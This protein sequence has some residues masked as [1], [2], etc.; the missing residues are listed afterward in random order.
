MRSMKHLILSITLAFS[1]PLIAQQEDF[2]SLFK[3]NTHLL[4]VDQGAFDESG[5]G[6]LNE[7]V[8]DAQFIMIGEAHGLAEVQEFSAMLFDIAHKEGFNIMA[9]ETDPFAADKIM[10]LAKQ[11]KAAATEFCRNFPMSIPFF[12]SEEAMIFARKLESISGKKLSIWGLD[13][14]FAVGPRLI[15]SQLVKIAPGDIAQTMA[16][17]YLKRS[18]SAFE[19]SMKT[20]DMEGFML[21]IL[22]ERDFDL[23]R[24]AFSHVNT[25]IEM[26][27]QME[28]S[29]EIYN[30]W[31]T[32]DGYLNNSVR[33]D[34]MKRLFRENY[35]NAKKTGE[36]FPKVVIKM[37]SYHC[38][39]GLSPTN[40]YDLGNMISETAALNGTK[41]LHI[42]L[43]A[44]KGESYNMMGGT[45]A[46]DETPDWHPWIKEALADQ[47]KDGMSDWL[48]VDLRPL[49]HLR[50]KNAD[51]EIKSLVFGF[52]LWVIIPEAHPV[53][54]IK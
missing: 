27:N 17:D 13:Q 9:V 18:T 6:I 21:S 11:D 36:E 49:R 16:L 46:F 41:S 44:A 7:G 12:H 53:T 8:A 40:I 47:I 25:A 4:S 34:L 54:P 37:G 14:V 30:Y 3:E 5:S 42:K 51:E 43:H 2:I 39:R 32:G 33:S 31:K 52:D 28:L 26:I 20:G 38:G 50:L 19:K 35:N 24:K 29:K 45:A 23:L 10:S 22:T 48:L 15:F 1:I